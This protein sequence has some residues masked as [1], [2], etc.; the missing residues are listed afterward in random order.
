MAIR[1]LLIAVLLAFIRPVSAAKLPQGEWIIVVG[2][3]SMHQWEKY[4]AQPHDHWSANFIH[5]GRIRTEQLR[6]EL[7][8][9]ATI[10]WL[11]YEAGYLEHEKQDGAELIGKSITVRDA[12]GLHLVY[13]DKGGEVINYLNNGQPRNE[14]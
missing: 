2:G 11:V 1:F 5:A 13:F 9:N 4:K 14:L 10:T 8:G 7:G 12:Y 6:A 3:V